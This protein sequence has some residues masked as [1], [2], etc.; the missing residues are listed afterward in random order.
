MVVAGEIVVDIELRGKGVLYRYGHVIETNGCVG[1][2][3]YEPSW[4][5]GAVAAV[6]AHYFKIYLWGISWQKKKRKRG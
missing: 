5:N 1:M 3:K 2:L 6:A 4:H